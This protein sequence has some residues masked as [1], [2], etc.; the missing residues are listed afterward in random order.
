MELWKD[1]S[2]APEVTK[3]HDWPSAQRLL[4]RSGDYE[5]TV[6]DRDGSALGPFAERVVEL[7]YAH[8]RE[9]LT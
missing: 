7:K 2:L 3:Q 8:H 4:A 9:Q 1:W 6:L 5:L